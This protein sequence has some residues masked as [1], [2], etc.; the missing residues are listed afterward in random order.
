M[1][2]LKQQLVTGSLDALVFREQKPRSLLEKQLFLGRAHTRIE[3]SLYP[4][5]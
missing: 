2:I 1:E 3:T 5:K 4:F